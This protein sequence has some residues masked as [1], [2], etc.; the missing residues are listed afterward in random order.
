MELRFSDQGAG[1]VEVCSGDQWHAVT[2]GAIVNNNT[3]GN[4]AVIARDSTSV[5]IRYTNNQRVQEYDVSCTN[6]SDGQIQSTTVAGVSRETTKLQ[7]NGLAPDTNYTCCAT[8]Y[9][10][11]SV[12]IDIISLSCTTTNTLRLDL[13]VPPPTTFTASQVGDGLFMIGFWTVLGICVLVLFVC[14]GFIIGCLVALK[15]QNRLMK[16]S[17]G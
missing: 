16:Y 17:I 2:N 7:I 5:M 10:M 12:P 6:V 15:Q 1:N 11:T 13:P 8:A 4:I 14:V 3:R 9:M